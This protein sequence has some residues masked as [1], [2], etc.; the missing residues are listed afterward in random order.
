MNKR[1]ETSGHVRWSLTL[2]DYTSCRM[3]YVS[4][5]LIL[6]LLSA[7]QYEVFNIVLSL[8]F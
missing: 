3:Y 7:Y 2:T 4:L 5:Y 8:C 1:T 6:M